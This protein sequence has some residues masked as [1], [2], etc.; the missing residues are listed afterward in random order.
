MNKEFR[1]SPVKTKQKS[2]KTKFVNRLDIL[3]KMI[4]CVQLFDF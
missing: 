4:I 2:K 1:F 3:V